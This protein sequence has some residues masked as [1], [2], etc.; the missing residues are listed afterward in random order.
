M[1]G[2]SNTSDLLLITVIVTE[3]LPLQYIAD[4]LDVDVY[5]RVYV[6]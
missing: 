3:F 6:S 2:A 5:V 4:L 1:W